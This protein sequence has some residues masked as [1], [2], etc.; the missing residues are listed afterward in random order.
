MEMRRKSSPSGSG[1]SQN[2]AAEVGTTMPWPLPVRKCSLLVVDDDD[3]IDNVNDDDDSYFI[4]S[5][6]G[7]PLR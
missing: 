3:D 1:T 5:L 4:L 2:F 6:T 7:R